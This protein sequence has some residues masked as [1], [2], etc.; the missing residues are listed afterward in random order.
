MDKKE[1]EELVKQTNNK[2]K[3]TPIK[4]TDGYKTK[5]LTN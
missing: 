5:A 4:S 2:N 1:Y 3:P